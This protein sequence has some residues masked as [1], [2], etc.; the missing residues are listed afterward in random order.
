[1]GPVLALIFLSDLDNKIENVATMFAD[2]TRLLANIKDETDVENLQCDLNKVYNWATENNMK[3]N[4]GKFEIL[5]YGKNEELKMNTLYFSADD[6]VIEQKDVL[7]D[8]G[9]QM[10]DKAT[11]DEH[12]SKVCQKVNRN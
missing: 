5:R 6:D 2:D 1:M 10:N 7:R 12:I 3:F 11:F 4:S 8:L 9:V